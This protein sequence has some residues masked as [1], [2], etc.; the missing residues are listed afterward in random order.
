MENGENLTREIFYPEFQASLQLQ[1][2][3]KIQAGK[4]FI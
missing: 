3:S 2:M 1:M 4:S